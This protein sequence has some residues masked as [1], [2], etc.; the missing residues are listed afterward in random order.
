M[1]NTQTH[2]LTQIPACNNET[3]LKTVL[4]NTIKPVISGEQKAVLRHTWLTLQKKMDTVGVVS[5]LRL[6]ETHPETLTPFLKH[7]NAAKEIRM[8]QW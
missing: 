3:Q 8:D 4:G 7:I 6:F 2:P 5:F 1:G